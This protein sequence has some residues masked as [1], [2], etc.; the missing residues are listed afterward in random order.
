MRF[1]SLAFALALLPLL[2]GCDEACTEIGCGPAV[3]LAVGNSDAPLDL[4]IATHQIDL[5]LDGQSVVVTCQSGTS[6][7][8]VESA[9]GPFSVTGVL[10]DTIDIEIFAQDGEAPELI[11]I[12]VLAG[13]A[14]IY[15]NAHSPEYSDTEIN[16][17]GCGV[18]RSADAPIIVPGS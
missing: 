14:Q 11:E 16:G 17:E 7:C 2:H 15:E 5:D 12:Y 1:L 8:E 3:R 13:D 18:C 4:A 6:D 9:E 10:S